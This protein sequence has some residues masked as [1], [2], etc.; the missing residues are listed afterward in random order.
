MA[1][2]HRP[3]SGPPVRRGPRRDTAIES[4]YKGAFMRSRLE[5]DFAKQLD[6]RD[7]HWTY[8]PERLGGGRYLVDFYLPDLGCWVEV[9]GRFEARDHLLLPNVAGHL[10]SERGEQLFLYMRAR[11]YH[12]TSRGFDELD[13]AAFWEAITTPPDPDSGL[14]YL[15]RRR[16]RQTPDDNSSG[17]A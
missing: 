9:K 13:R 8:E 7:I 11:T 2:P 5:V 4:I 10:R 14:R 12:V 6:A 16:A 1:E 15:A 3:P 17:D